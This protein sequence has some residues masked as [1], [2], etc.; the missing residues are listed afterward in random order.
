APLFPYTTLFRSA[1]AAV[2]CFDAGVLVAVLAE[3]PRA[4]LDLVV[5]IVRSGFALA[6]ADHAVPRDR[7]VLHPQLHTQLDRF[8]TTARSDRQPLR[9]GRR[10]EARSQYRVGDSCQ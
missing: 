1:D 4:V 9:T 3:L 6:V 5:G 10:G 7:V 2:T 8:L